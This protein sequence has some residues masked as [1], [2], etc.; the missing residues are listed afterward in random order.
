MTMASLALCGD[1]A[2]PASKKVF[3]EARLGMNLNGP[4]DWNCELPFVDVLRLSR[5]WTARRGGNGPALPLD[6][7]G[8]V[9]KLDVDCS[10]ETPLCMIEGG[11]VA[12]C[13]CHPAVCPLASMARMTRRE[14]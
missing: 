9:K 7:H 11:R 8:W 3:P 4:A 12:A 13:V 1:A 5:P 10:A 6:R 2:R 14:K